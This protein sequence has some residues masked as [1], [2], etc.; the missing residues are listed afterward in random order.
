MHININTIISILCLIFVIVVLFY[1]L[2]YLW[3]AS[4]KPKNVD[5][6]IKELFVMQNS[7]QSKDINSRIYTKNHVTNYYDKVEKIMREKHPFPELTPIEKQYKDSCIESMQ[8]IKLPEGMLHFGSHELSFYSLS[9]AIGKTID[10]RHMIGTFNPNK[11]IIE[12]ANKVIKS[13]D[14]IDNPDVD[15]INDKSL[16]YYGLGRDYGKNQLKIYMITYNFRDWIPW[17]SNYI[18]ND[19]QTRLNTN[20]NSAL[21]DDKGLVSITI[22]LNTKKTVDYKLYM[23]PTIEKPVVMVTKSRGLVDQYDVKDLFDEIDLGDF[24]SD[25]VMTLINYFKQ[26]EI[27]VDTYSI[28]NNVYSL[29]F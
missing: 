14:L 27:N 16:V 20:A 29:Y 22:D 9:M 13:Y 5:K 18:D 8:H 24:V 7:S 6:G 21:F 25:D 26:H 1:Y 11:T 3:T 10:I 4:I 23:Y 12:N 17:I 28:H 19:V 15:I 2:K